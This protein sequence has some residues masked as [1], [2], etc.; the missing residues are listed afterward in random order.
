M[1]LSVSRIFLLSALPL[2]TG[3]NLPDAPPS[4][5]PDSLAD[6]QAGIKQEDKTSYVVKTSV[7]LELKNHIDLKTFQIADQYLRMNLPI[8]VDRSARKSQTVKLD[9]QYLPDFLD[10]VFE[11]LK[12]QKLSSESRKKILQYFERE[13]GQ[14]K[15]SLSNTSSAPYIRTIQDK[16]YVMTTPDEWL[17]NPDVAFRLKNYARWHAVSETVRRAGGKLEIIYGADPKG[18]PKEVWTRDKYVLVG[19]VAFLPDEE[20]AQQFGGK[21]AEDYTSEIQQAEDY[22]K[23]Q[24]VRTVRVKWAWFEG[25]NIIIHKASRTI[26]LGVAVDAWD[27]SPKLLEE[28][29]KKN[30]GLN[31]EVVPVPM[32]NFH[33]SK[34]SPRKNGSYLYH[35]DTGLSEPLPNG[36]VLLSR[37]LTDAPTLK[38]ISDRVGEKNIIYLSRADSLRYTANIMTV[39][40]TIISPSMS[41]ALRKN[42]EGR[43]YN[44]VEGKDFD[45]DRLSFGMGG[46]HCNINVL[47]AQKMSI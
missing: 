46:P 27:E 31:Y 32:V 7:P 23:L 8:H 3:I 35:L 14:Y 18:G 47:P 43:G 6:V 45:L 19:D 42:L 4:A 5:L 34:I 38:K 26:F 11:Q 29:V 39:G 1:K 12:T 22:L 33:N 9:L 21:A 28:A 16:R 24:G 40:N 37:D 10:S 2:L 44:V 13:L 17:V 15:I 41:P 36:E 30:T 25:G 20:K